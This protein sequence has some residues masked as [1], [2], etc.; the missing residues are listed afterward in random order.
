MLPE[1]VSWTHRLAI[2]QTQRRFQEL[3]RYTRAERSGSDAPYAVVC[4][5]LLW[6]SIADEGFDLIFGPR[7]SQRYEALKRIRGSS[8]LGQH[9]KAARWARNRMTHC[10][11]RPVLWDAG[12]DRQRN[13]VPLLRW[14][15]PRHILGESIGADERSEGLTEYENLFVGQDV[16]YTLRPVVAWV[17]EVRYDFRDPGWADKWFECRED[18]DMR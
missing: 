12:P 5:V 1:G 8:V 9:M 18:S 10:L 11:A 3:L 13:D 7:G 4:E 6:A 15:P 16:V 17:S 2:D 14:L